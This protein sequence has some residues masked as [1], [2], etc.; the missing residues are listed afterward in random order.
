MWSDEGFADL[1]PRLGRA[2]ERCARGGGKAVEIQR[3]S[4]A[5]NV[6]ESWCRNQDHDKV[7]RQSATGFWPERKTVI[8]QMIGS[9]NFCG[10]GGRI[11]SQKS[12]K[13]LRRYGFPLKNPAWY[14]ARVPRQGT[15]M[16][17]TYRV[18]HSERHP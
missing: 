3:L 7:P 15:T 14:H 9:D 12:A 13:L 4:C 18:T 1:H 6:V 8:F 2:D 10:W 5:G 11:P 17:T 16:D